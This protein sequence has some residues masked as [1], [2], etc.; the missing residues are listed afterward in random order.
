M[1]TAQTTLTLKRVV[2]TPSGAGLFLG[3]DRKTFVIYVDLLMGEQINLALKKQAQ[4]RPLTF[5]FFRYVL[6]SFEISVETIVI[7]R[8]ENG[9]FYSRVVMT[10]NDA[11]QRV[12]EMDIRTSDAILLSL[13]MNKPLL[14]ADEVFEKVPD[15]TDI[16][17]NFNKLTA[18]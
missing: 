14:I 2:T 6:Q 18:Q 7:Y 11:L 4:P 1:K 3:N 10:Q 8:A 17:N 15:A 9:V 5:D 12:A 13:T 16:L